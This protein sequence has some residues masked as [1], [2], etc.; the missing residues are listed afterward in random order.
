[1]H[2]KMTLNVYLALSLLLITLTSYGQEIQPEPQQKAPQKKNN[3]SA[4]ITKGKQELNQ[5]VEEINQQVENLNQQVV[6]NISDQVENIELRDNINTMMQN[7]ADWIDGL[8]T[9]E[10]DPQDASASGYFQLG[11]LPRT[12]DWR[13]LDA[14]LKVHFYLPN[15][16][17][18]L[19]V[20][21]ENDNE[22]EVDLD[23]EAGSFVQDNT[24]NLNIA[25]QNYRKIHDDLNIRNRVGFSRG[26]LYLRSEVKQSWFF[27]KSTITLTPRIGYY[28]SDGW[29]PSI[30]AGWLRTLSEKDKLSVSASAQKVQ[31][32]EFSRLKFGVYHIHTASAS[33]LLVSG[34]QYNR[35]EEGYNNYLVSIRFRQQLNQKWAYIEFEPFVEFEER[36][37][38]HRE[39]GIAF[40]FIGYYGGKIN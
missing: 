18:K 27:E 35:D 26:Q 1:M 20:V 24:N 4:A 17:N 40:N 31:S 38:Y 33:N 13:E 5:K 10:P 9:D 39:I 29:A 12:S 8:I 7:T 14:K 21:L 36:L 3:S 37:D 23:Y 22:E 28:S 25:L 34:A 15:W 2:T 19:A 16:E 11:W 6:D 32:E 30:K